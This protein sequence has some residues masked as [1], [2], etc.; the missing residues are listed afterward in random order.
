MASQPQRRGNSSRSPRGNRLSGRPG[1]DEAS[2]PRPLCAMPPF[3]A[4]RSHRPGVA[5]L[6]GQ[7]GSRRGGCRWY[8]RDSGDCC[9]LSCRSAS[10]IASHCISCGRVVRPRPAVSSSHRTCAARRDVALRLVR[11]VVAHAAKSGVLCQSPDHGGDKPRG[12]P[13]T[14]TASALLRCTCLTITR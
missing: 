13:V 1:D 2:S 4:H 11:Q 12:A 5:A 6:E 10:H 8:P 3:A 14:T 9:R 7:A